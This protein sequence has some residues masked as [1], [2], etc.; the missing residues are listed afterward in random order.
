VPF[1]VSAAHKA[2]AT[3]LRVS[4]SSLRPAADFRYYW[5]SRYLPLVAGSLRRTVDGQFEKLIFAV[6]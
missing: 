4:Q 1:S 6:E 5:I 2:D 3:V